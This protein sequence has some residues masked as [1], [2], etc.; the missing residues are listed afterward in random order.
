MY[1]LTL[2]PQHILEHI[3]GNRIL[4]VCN[5]FH[6]FSVVLFFPFLHDPNPGCFSLVVVL[7]KT[8]EVIN[9]CIVKT[10]RAE[11]QRQKDD[12]KVSVD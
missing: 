10:H 9:A 7:L 3:C 6:P 12:V 5:H 2:R 8:P 11:N 1:I 4:K